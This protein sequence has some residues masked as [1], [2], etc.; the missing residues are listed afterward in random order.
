MKPEDQTAVEKY[1][2][3]FATGDPDGTESPL[4]ASACNKTLTVMQCNCTSMRLSWEGIAVHN[5]GLQF[6]VFHC[7]ISTT[8]AVTL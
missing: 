7:M 5:M 3:L 1:S 2:V 6:V 8:P 4:P